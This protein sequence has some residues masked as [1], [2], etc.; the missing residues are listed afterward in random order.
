VTISPGK[1]ILQREK[2]HWAIFRL[3]SPCSSSTCSRYNIIT[4]HK[5]YIIY[6]DWNL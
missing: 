2:E 4:N 1:I 5:R 3:C 6:K